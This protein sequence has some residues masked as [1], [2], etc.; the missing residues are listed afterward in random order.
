MQSASALH[1][2]PESGF[3]S[4]LMDARACCIF[5]VVPEDAAPPTAGGGSIADAGPSTQS[6]A[7]ALPAGLQFEH[8]RPSRGRT[9]LIR[10]TASRLCPQAQTEAVHHRSPGHAHHD[11]PQRCCGELVACTAAAAR[12]S[13][14][15]TMGALTGSHG[16]QCRWRGSRMRRRWRRAPSKTAGRGWTISWHSCRRWGKGDKQTRTQC[17]ARAA[18]TLSVSAAA[19]FL[20]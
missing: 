1:D 6:T 4:R 20:A 8:V 7:Q 12:L 19:D 10:R 14:G 9:C 11:Q 3:D 13:C 17:A 15:S 5:Q 16:A 18:L 2:H